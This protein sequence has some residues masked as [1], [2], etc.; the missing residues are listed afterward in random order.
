MSCVGVLVVIVVIWDGCD[1]ICVRFRSFF[2]ILNVFIII[3]VF[4]F[5]WVVV[6]LS[7]VL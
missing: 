4:F 3:F 2:V 1:R 7:V 5:L 6:G